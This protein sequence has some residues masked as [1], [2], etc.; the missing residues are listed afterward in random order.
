MVAIPA[1]HDAAIDL[2]GVVKIYRGRVHALRGIEMH[3]NRG[4]IFGLLGP[5]GAGKSTLVKI[6]MTVISPTRC[7][8]HVLG[9]PV[10]DKATLG[11]IG[12]LPEH[13]KFPDYLTGAQVLDFYGAMGK[14]PREER[15]RRAGELLELVGM[16]EWADKKVRGYSKGMRQR[17]GVAQSLMNDPDLVLLDEPTDG[18][19]PVGRRDIRNICAEIKARGKTVMLNSHLLSELEMVCDRVA[20][21]VQGAVSSQGTINE[22]TRDQERYEIEFSGELPVAAM[23]AISSLVIDGKPPQLSPHKI[24][25]H[26]AEAADIQ[27]AIDTLRAS[28]VVIHSVRAVRPSLEDLFMQAVTDPRTGQVLKPGAAPPTARRRAPAGIGGR[29]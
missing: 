3:V 9:K 20:I 8:G 23:N 21:L 22:L 11:R 1:Q 26:R 14:V 10:G 15:R 29:S 5:N 7:T 12:Y 4:E 25:V 28:G 6:L 27:P 2:K 24:V 18:V 17:I 13:H 16:T 19:D